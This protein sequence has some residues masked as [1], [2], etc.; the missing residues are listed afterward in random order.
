ML[1]LSAK[2]SVIVH[3][4]YRDVFNSAVSIDMLIRWLPQFTEAELR[5]VL[6]DLIAD[7]SVETIDGQ[8]FCLKGRA[9]ILSSFAA[10][11]RLSARVIRRY[12]TVLR[13]IGFLPFVQYVGVCGSVA[14]ENPT[15]D[16]CGENAGTFD[17][18]VFLI[19]SVNAAWIVLFFE[20][21]Y[22]NVTRL[23]NNGRCF[24]CLN[25]T[26][27]L[28]SLEIDNKNLFTA[29]D[30]FNLKTIYDRHNTLETF[31]TA[32]KWAAHYYPALQWA[33][34]KRRIM[35][36]PGG[37]FVATLNFIFFSLFHLCRALKHGNV[38]LASDIAT[39]FSRSLP[40]SLYRRT[41]SDRGYEV[42]IR[43][44]FRQI[45]ID[46]FSDSLP[47]SDLVT[48]AFPEREVYFAPDPKKA[49]AFLKY[50]VSLK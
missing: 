23:L 50:S 28:S 24:F 26:V 22:T 14:A 1:T 15:P 38:K 41:S 49:E 10:K 12:S 30:I 8:V 43:Q 37:A 31:V 18:D 7:G 2:Q 46:R 9:E 20:R 27:D 25:Y 13:L 40:E 44:K 5:Q 33:T 17:V 6:L 48:S 3:I 39:G 42:F 4:A 45:L 21:L 36:G 19:T 32:N 29:T 16:V 47:V 11:R 35:G 34:K